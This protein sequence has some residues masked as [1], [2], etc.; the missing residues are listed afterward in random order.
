MKIDDGYKLFNCEVLI[1]ILCLDCG[2]LSVRVNLFF[3]AYEG[4]N[5]KA[6]SSNKHSEYGCPDVGQT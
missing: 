1:E 4:A 5:L 6:E 2:L 3:F